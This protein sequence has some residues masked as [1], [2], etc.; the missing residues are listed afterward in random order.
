[1]APC[2]PMLP[3]T[4]LPSSNRCG[5]WRW[6]ARPGYRRERADEQDEPMPRCRRD[7]GGPGWGIKVH[8]DRYSTMPTRLTNN[9]LTDLLFLQAEHEEGHR[10]R[11]LERAG[12]AAMFS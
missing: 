10:R 8:G 12:R 2:S 11:A 3:A 1:M 5:R 6:F 7:S 4:E 9:R